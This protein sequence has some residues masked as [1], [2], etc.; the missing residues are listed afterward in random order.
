MLSAAVVLVPLQKGLN[1]ITGTMTYL[2]SM[3]LKKFTIV[4][5]A[6]AVREYVEAG[7]TGRVVDGS[8][9]DYVKTIRWA[10]APENSSQ[11]ARICEQAHDTVNRRFTLERHGKDLLDIMK[12]IAGKADVLSQPAKVGG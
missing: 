10:M 7:I 1:R 3:W 9:E 11:I 12:E 6:L 8:T 4:P 5:D 2:K